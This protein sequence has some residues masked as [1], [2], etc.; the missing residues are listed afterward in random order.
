MELTNTSKTTTKKSTLCSSRQSAMKLINHLHGVEKTSTLY[1]EVLSNKVQDR[2][3]KSVLLEQLLPSIQK[4]KETLYLFL[5]IMDLHPQDTDTS[6]INGIMNE[7][8]REIEDMGNEGRVDD[9]ILQT[10]VV[11]LHYK[12][13][14]YRILLSYLQNL[15][16]DFKVFI[17]QEIIQRDEHHLD[18]LLAAL[19]LD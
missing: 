14:N 19:K 7:C 11:I 6:G 12:L 16:I 17:L 10:L 8:F 9:I 18:T 2:W 5:R 1:H 13:G 3:I 4:K 15:D